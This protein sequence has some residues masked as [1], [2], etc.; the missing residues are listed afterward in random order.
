M[1]GIKS[2]EIVNSQVQRVKNLRIY[3][4]LSYFVVIRKETVEYP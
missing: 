1:R 4:D 3:N 2:I